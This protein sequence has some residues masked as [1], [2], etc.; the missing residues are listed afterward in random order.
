MEDHLYSINQYKKSHK[1]PE[2]KLH[3]QVLDIEQPRNI[4]LS[5]SVNNRS[6]L[7]A[8]TGKHALEQS[9]YHLEVSTQP[10][11]IKPEVLGKLKS[12]AW[13]FN[14][15]STLEECN[16]LAYTLNQSSGHLP[17]LNR[18]M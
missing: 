13:K 9:R 6:E 12:N 2:A 1:K 4:K 5:K 8:L 14:I 18:Y 7:R 3:M 17:D 11:P 10:S 15:R 16:R